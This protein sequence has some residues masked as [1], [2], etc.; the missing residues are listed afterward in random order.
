MNQKRQP[1]VSILIPVYNG[2]PFLAETIASIKKNHYPNHEVILVNDGSS[3]N[4]KL[5]CREFAKNSKKIRFYS[6][7]Q[8]QGMTRVLNFG[9]A[10]AKGKYIARLNQDDLIMPNRLEKQVK[11]LEQ[12]PDYVAVGG[13]IKLFTEGNP[14]FGQVNFPLTDKKIRQNWLMFSPY[15]DPTVT[16]RKESVLR[17]E[18]YSQYFWPADDVHMWYQL[19]KLGKLA[20]LSGVMTKVR[21]HQSCGSIKSHKRQ[22]LKTWQVHQWAAENVAKPSSGLRIFWACQLL[23]GYLCPPQFNWAV[24]RL[25]KKIQ[26]LSF[27]QIKGKILGI[28]NKLKIVKPQ[29]AMANLSGE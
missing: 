9:I 17:T 15:S 20:N 14:K 8:N 19:G 22:M 29:P 18:G 26:F 25:I 16:Y 12:H 24:Y 10:K 13:Q 27:D 5:V 6:F 11:F 7:D 21:W 1:L 28:I 4:S 2:A 3:D 23:A